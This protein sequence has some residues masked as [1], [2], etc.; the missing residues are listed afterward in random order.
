MFGGG[1]RIP[2]SVGPVASTR[3][4]LFAMTVVGL[5]GGGLAI[6][7]STV[8]PFREPSI[9]RLGLDAGAGM[10]V[11]ATL[12]GL[13]LC[14]LALGLCLREALLG[15]RDS[16]SRAVNDLIPAGFAVAGIGLVL[17][18]IFSVQTPT[19][20]TVHNL[21]GFTTPLVLMAS[22]IG[23]RAAL[24]SLGRALD[25]FS[26]LA[27][28]GNALLYALA[29]RLHLLP[30]PMMELACFGLI[31]VWLWLFEARLERAA[32]PSRRASCCVLEAAPS[33][34]PAAARGR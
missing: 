8:D 26:V 2:Q 21:A 7:R 25:A 12:I 11:N 13:G 9:S 34:P 32:R 31:G 30:Y 15:L 20:T 23:G 10:I 29:S 17:A 1:P 14:L 33:E 6:D 4:C 19:S 27:V 5:V 3:A 24:G 18:A 16:P 22:L 28:A